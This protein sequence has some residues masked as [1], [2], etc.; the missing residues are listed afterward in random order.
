MSWAS[1][2]FHFLVPHSLN[3][4]ETS[5]LTPKAGANRGHAPSTIREGPR[6]HSGSALKSTIR[7]AS[8]PVQEPFLALWACG[9]PRP[10]YLL[11]SARSSPP[12]SSEL[13]PCCPGHTDAGEH[14]VPHPRR[15]ALVS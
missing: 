13:R 2:V 3:L 8:R 5:V 7:N 11:S 12:S 10:R 14:R 15:S 4:S 1:C 9:R 6:V